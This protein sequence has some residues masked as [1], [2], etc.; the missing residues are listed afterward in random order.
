MTALIAGSLLVAMA[1][2]SASAAL[3]SARGTVSCLNGEPVEGV[4]ISAGRQSGWATINPSGGIQQIVSYYKSFKSASHYWV[5]VGC[6]GETSDWAEVDTSWSW[7]WPWP[8]GEYPWYCQQGTCVAADG[9][10]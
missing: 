2:A 10:E 6:G 5:T 8:I 9:G 3:F 1:P 7:A 4:W